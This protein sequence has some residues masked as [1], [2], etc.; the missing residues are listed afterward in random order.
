M[1]SQEWPGRGS[2]G[3]K[4]ID[5]SAVSNVL[6]AAKPRFLVGQSPDRRHLG[7][8][9]PPSQ[10]TRWGGGDCGEASS[11][12]QLSKNQMMCRDGYLHRGSV[13]A[14]GGGPASLE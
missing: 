12:R 10:R 11:G 1:R 14:K 8:T 13:I 7:C 6:Q 9:M 2:G 5:G 3:G 4:Q